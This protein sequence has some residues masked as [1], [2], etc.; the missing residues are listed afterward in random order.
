MNSLRWSAALLASLASGALAQP[1][2]LSPLRTVE[3]VD[4]ARY[5]GT[6]HEIARFPFGI[7]EQ[8]ARDTTAIY[9]A[10]HDGAIGVLNRC[11][12]AD[13]SLFSA[14]AVAWVVDPQSNARLQV[15]FLPA[16]LRW[17]PAGRGDYWVIDLAPDYSFAV[18]GEP[19]RRYLWI[20]ARTPHMDAAT[21]RA[22]TERLTAQGYDPARLLPS[23][24]RRLPVP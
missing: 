9:S 13:G 24:G 2:G 10:R 20:L 18:V 22:I 6:W 4:L 23:P 17:L 19:Q 14:A 3:H 1:A 7:Q 16:W 11:L 12:R 21:F 8:C 5:L 15:S